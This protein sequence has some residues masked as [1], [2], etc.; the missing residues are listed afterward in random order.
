MHHARII[1]SQYAMTFVILELAVIDKEI[2]M[3]NSGPD[4]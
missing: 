1:Y 4:N 3:E 2:Y